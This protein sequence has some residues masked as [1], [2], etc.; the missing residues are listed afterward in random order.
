MIQL[1]WMKGGFNMEKR[2]FGH[3]DMH[4]SI[5]GF[6]G[7]EIGF[8][9]M[10]AAEVERLLDGAFAA[11]LNVIDT[12]PLYADSEELIGK[13]V[14][15]RRDE[16]YLFTKVG[17]P[18]N[19]TGR[20]AD[21]RWYLTEAK[22]ATPNDWKPAMLE[23]SIHRSLQR[24][25]TDYVDVIHLHC[26]SEE[27]LRKGEVIET[28]QKAKQAGKTR[29]IGYSGDGE[30]AL[31]AAQLG[32]IDSLMTSI[33][34]ADQQAIEMIIPKAI[35]NNMGIIAK[36]PIAN[37]AWFYRERPENLYFGY[38]VEYWER[39]RKLNYDFLQAETKSSIGMALRF[40]LS[41]PGVHTAIVGTTKPSRY[42][43]N[44]E[45]LSA[46][47]LDNKQVKAIMNRYREVA[48][49]DWVGQI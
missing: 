47:M 14:S 49:P 32:V 42:A 22:T 39:L 36:R 40:T 34:I 5:L 44:A 35:E 7:A 8:G 46:G 10:D 21:F 26:C 38:Y 41:I 4:V 3:T 16:Y 30:D 9:N 11:G 20:E 28:L 1:L 23:Q 24:L 25:R 18:A 17:N 6:G 2:K 33:N 19:P 48:Q 43:E 45:L 15:H 13:S 27:I 12:A 31:C 29:Y 37:R